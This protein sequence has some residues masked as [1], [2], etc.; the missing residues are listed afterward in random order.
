M[1]TVQHRLKQATLPLLMLAALFSVQHSAQAR[2]DRLVI[3][4]GDNSLTKEEA[5]QQKE[6]WDDTRNLRHKVN[7]RT[8]KEFD[9]VDRAFDTSEA[10]EKSLNLNAY[11]EPK[12]LRCLD[13]RT[14]RPVTP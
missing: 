1:K 14:G 12:T 13:R 4:D 8:E 5:R 9:R 2:T 7:S 3:E 11:W 10:C 6:Q